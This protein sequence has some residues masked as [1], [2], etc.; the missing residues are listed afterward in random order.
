MGTDNSQKIE[1]LPSDDEQNLD[2]EED[3]E[4]EKGICAQRKS[5]EIECG[6]YSGR[7]TNSDLTNND[8]NQQ[9]L[10]AT[11]ENARV[12]TPIVQKHEECIENLSLEKGPEEGEEPNQQLAS[13]RKKSSFIGLAKT[14]E[15]SLSED[16]KE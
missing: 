13:Q 4:V 12:E 7:A 11:T 5:N 10:T 8:E 6:P 2:E 3:D 1:S 15:E 14:L 9:Q 16:N